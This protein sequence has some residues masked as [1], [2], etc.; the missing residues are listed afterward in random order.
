MK[1]MVGIASGLAFAAMG[2]AIGLY[3]AWLGFSATPYNGQQ[4][5][6]FCAVMGAL[7]GCTWA[8][9]GALSGPW[10]KRYAAIAPARAA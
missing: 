7:V 4:L 10:Q 3:C 8:C 5:G 6:T 2:T 9:I 1:H